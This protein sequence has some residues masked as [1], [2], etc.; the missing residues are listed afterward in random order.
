VWRI[1]IHFPLRACHHIYSK[2]FQTI[3]RVLFIHCKL[4]RIKFNGFYIEAPIEA[5]M[6]RKEATYIFAGSLG[7][8]DPNPRQPAVGP[9]KTAADIYNRRASDIKFFA[10]YQPSIRLA[11]LW[12]SRRFVWHHCDCCSLE[13]ISA[14]GIA[15]S[16]RSSPA[17]SV[18][19]SSY[20]RIS[21]LPLK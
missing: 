12:F 9:K 15:S 13:K 8:S 5:S 2:K 19:S 11:P 4:I 3:R 14:D 17:I 6:L 7:I 1:K 16:N 10:I 20:L 21:K 18:G